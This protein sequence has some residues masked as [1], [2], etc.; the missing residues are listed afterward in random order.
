VEGSAEDLKTL[1]E[2]SVDAVFAAQVR[3]RLFLFLWIAFVELVVVRDCDSIQ[4]WGDIRPVR[5]GGETAPVSAA[6]QART[7]QSL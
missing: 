2:E 6:R 4:G 1:E 3:S 5:R 7:L